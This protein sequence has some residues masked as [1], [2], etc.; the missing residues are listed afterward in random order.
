[1]LDPIT[2]GY[3]TLHPA[4]AAQTLAR[5]SDRDIKA[6]FA[7]MPRQL[8]ADVLSHMAPGFATRCLAQLPVGTASAILA[9]APVPAAVAALRLMQSDH[10]KSLLEAMPRPAM[11]RL[12]LR[13]RFSEAVI[14]A[15]VDADV[16]TVTPTDR[17]GDVLR[18]LRRAGPPVSQMLPVLDEHH[19]LAGVVELGDLLTARDRS[20]IQ[21]VTRQAPI[22][23]NARSA[24]QTMVNDPVWL[25]HDS[26]PV[27]N[28]EGVF[29]G[30]LRR[31][32][33]VE[34]AQQLLNE[35]AD[36]ADLAKTRAALADIFWIGVGAFFAGN[37]DSGAQKLADE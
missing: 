27:T 20:L 9:Q 36:R 29:Q 16:M 1:M 23:L 13:L 26:L 15:Y 2:K 37:T 30:V 24:L 28:R 14:G 10:V 11:A 35:V 18:R 3:L 32:E 21:S 19:K 6:L 31:P 25:T 33:A 17:V 7:A 22:V 34:E 5:L 4:A 8:A 12:R